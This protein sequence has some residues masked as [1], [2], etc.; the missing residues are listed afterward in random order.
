MSRTGLYALAFGLLVA[1][2][3]ALGM[4]AVGFLAST[5]LL[6]LS[7]ALSGLAIVAALGSIVVR[8]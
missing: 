1:A 6:V 8:R 4:A 3:V 5:G 7:A 2:I